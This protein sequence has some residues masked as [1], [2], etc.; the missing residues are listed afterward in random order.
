MKLLAKFSIIFAVV[1]GLGLT[2]TG[3]LSYSLL[4]R[5]ARLQVEDRAK[6]MMETALAMRRYT[7]DQV[8]PALRETVAGTPAAT[9]KAFHP[10]IVPAFAA[11][12]M[13][14]YLREK[15]PDYFYKEAALNPT[16]PRDRAED[17]EADII[18]NFRNHADLKVF[19]GDRM[20]PMGKSLYLA[21][22]LHAEASCLECHSTPAAAPAAMIE[23]YGPANGFGWKQGEVIAAQIV[24]VPAALPVE[25]ADREFRQ[26]MTLL[27]C[28]G[29]VTL[30]VLN[31]VL[32]VLVIRPV[33]Q[34][35]ERA[36]QISEGKMDVPELPCRGKCEISMLVASFNRMHRSL[37]AAMKMLD[38][39]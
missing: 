22:P 26:L 18:N 37:L 30:L 11:T 6:I 39:E 5:N 36:E 14:N 23:R 32:V 29:A 4:Q 3:F 25:M 10:E 9:A 17:W 8:K 38:K 35:A 7:V 16:N 21:R 20:T 15:Y 34:L 33:G 2:A 27:L 28:V 31:V 24:S 1:F 19:D 13:F 12:E